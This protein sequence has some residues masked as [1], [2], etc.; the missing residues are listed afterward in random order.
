ML[1][2]GFTEIFS[3]DILIQFHQNTCQK[4]QANV[5]ILLLKLTLLKQY[6]NICTV[7]PS[8]CSDE[9]DKEADPQT[10][11]WVH[12]RKTTAPKLIMEIKDGDHYSANGP[13]GGT[14]SEFEQGSEPCMLCN[15][16]FAYVCGCAPCPM[17]T[18]N[19]STGHARSE[20]HR[21]AVGGIVLAW[22]Q[23]FLLGDESARS[24]LEAQPDIASGF[25][26][27]KMDRR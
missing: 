1:C 11:A 14:Q 23:L 20:A 22:L 10:Q 4:L 5:I 12:Y 27:E 24:R 9:K 26:S 7:V 18:L 13:S 25:E 16:C 8:S 19:G 21:G 3:V 6:S 2:D 17:G 15:C